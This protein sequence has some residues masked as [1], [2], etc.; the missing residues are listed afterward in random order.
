MDNEADDE[1]D[2]EVVAAVT[3]FGIPAT[4]NQKSVYLN[5]IA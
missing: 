2:D 5:N 4:M 1:I 3:E